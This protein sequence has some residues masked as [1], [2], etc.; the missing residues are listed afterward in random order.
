MSTVRRES[1]L[2]IVACLCLNQVHYFYVFSIEIGVYCIS[3]S[4]FFF[5][6]YSEN[7]N[8]I[9]LNYQ[10]ESEGKRPVPIMKV[11]EISNRSLSTMQRRTTYASL[12]LTRA[13]FLTAFEH[14]GCNVLVVT[15]KAP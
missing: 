3:G 1:K 5:P 8:N 11:Q 12:I 9:V 13:T 6:I 2:I 15:R 4:K 7:A 10:S 14:N